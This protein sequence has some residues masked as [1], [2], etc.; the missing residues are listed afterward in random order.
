MPLK[1]VT[2]TDLGTYG[3][4]LDEPAPRML[5]EALKLYGVTEVLGPENNPEIISWAS[6][7]GL[8][9]QYDQDVTPWCGLFV[10]VVALRA[11]KPRP[12]DP[13]WARNW[14]NWGSACEPMLGCVLVFSRKGG[15]GHVGLYVGECA[16]Y[17]YVLSGNQKDKVC[18][19]P[20]EKQRLLGARELYVVAKPA[21]VRKVFLEKSGAVSTNEI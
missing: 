6:E 14:L 5:P 18:V 20:I 2:K 10:S 17:Y 15:G 13:L 16:D 7:C 21:N 3:W 8:S 19:V 12:K 11:G 1:P 4:L 9:A